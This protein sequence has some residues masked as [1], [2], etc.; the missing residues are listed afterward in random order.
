MAPAMLG[1]K[2]FV[3]TPEGVM[4]DTVTEVSH[5]GKGWVQ[6]LSFGGRS[7]PA[8][9]TAEKLIY[10]HNMIK[11]PDSLDYRSPADIGDSW[12]SVYSAS[13]NYGGGGASNSSGGSAPTNFGIPLPGSGTP[14]NFGIPMPGTGT[15]PGFGGTSYANMGGGLSAAGSDYAPIGSS[16]FGLPSAIDTKSFDQSMLQPSTIAGDAKPGFWNSVWDSKY[17]APAATL[18]LGP[19]AGVA[20]KGAQTYTHRNE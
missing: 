17:L 6:P 4:T 9:D 7:F 5:I 14:S 1:E 18:L 16:G 19:L 15:M 20:V 10:S 3:H 8:G 2:V 12:N 13:G 11:T